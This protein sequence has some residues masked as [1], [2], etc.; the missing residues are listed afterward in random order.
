MPLAHATV[1]ITVQRSHRDEWDDV[2]YVDHHQITGCLDYRNESTEDTGGAG[3]RDSGGLGERVTDVRTVLAPPGSDVL[4]TDRVLIHPRGMDLVP[5][6]D[7][8]TRQANTYQVTGRPQD[9]ENPVTGWRPGMEINL[10][11]TS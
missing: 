8:V 2:T 3:N 6:N 9:W 1:T 10:T 4:Y 5:A 7:K 11:R